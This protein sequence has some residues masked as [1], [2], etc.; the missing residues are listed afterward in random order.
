MPSGLQYSDKDEMEEE[1]T[2]IVIRSPTTSDD[3]FIMQ[4]QRSLKKY[5]ILNITENSE[6]PEQDNGTEPEDDENTQPFE[7]SEVVIIDQSTKSPEE[8]ISTKEDFEELIDEGSRKEKLKMVEPKPEKQ[9]VYSFPPGQKSQVVVTRPSNL[10][11]VS[12]IAATPILQNSKLSSEPQ[13]LILTPTSKITTS[14]ASSKL[15][16]II[17]THNAM[18]SNILSVQGSKLPSQGI[19]I[20][21]ATNSQIASILP[22]KFTVPVISASAVRQLPNVKVIDKPSSSL[23]LSA[24]EGS[25]PKKIFDDDSVSPDNGSMDDEKKNVFEE[26]MKNELSASKLF[27]KNVVKPEGLIQRQKITILTDKR[28]NV[29]TQK[30]KVQILTQSTTKSSS[31]VIIH[32]AP[33]ELKMTA[34]VIQEMQITATE[35]LS[36]FD[37]SN[38]DKSVVISIPSPT[39]SQE[40]MLDNIAL[41]ALEENR[42][43]EFES[44]EDVLDMIENMQHTDSEVDSKQTKPKEVPVESKKQT[45][46]QLS[47]LS[48]PADLTTN[49]ANASQQLR[50]LLSTIQTTSTAHTS[51]VETLVKSGQKVVNVSSASST[52]VASRVIQPPVIVP[53][54]AKPKPQATKP[55]EK[56]QEAPKKTSLTLTAMLQ[57]QPAATPTTKPSADTI[58]AASLLATPVSLSRTSFS[59]AL[60]QAQPNAII[61]AVTANTS[62]IATSTS[63]SSVISSSFRTSTNLLHTQLTKSR[64]KS[65][66]DI[67]DL[68][69]EESKVATSESDIVSS[70]KQELTS[71]KF[72]A[73]TRYVKPMKSVSK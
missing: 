53:N 51:N 40:Q 61:A 35:T 21:S 22:S 19:T 63:S 14:N 52:V 26:K 42:R 71:S 33:P 16:S 54:I 27:A 36:T 44:F 32:H 23:S 24:P 62:G 67:K 3:E 72:S 2:N 9:T 45:M 13:Q 7:E 69:S 73:I 18:R 66:D 34:Q 49:M 28:E 30:E 48:Q 46:P 57:N 11:K 64:T 70:I 55:Q 17:L 59:P 12:F 58:T 60:A 37:G 25:L 41:Q 15:T 39:P 29:E 56:P 47:P 50:T 38:E 8:Q 6:S 43:R 10:A 1:Y 5:N 68:K 4:D 31:P 20:V 65:L